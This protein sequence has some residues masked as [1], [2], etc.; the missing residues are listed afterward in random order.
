MHS[1]SVVKAPDFDRHSSPDRPLVA[2]FVGVHD[3]P[4]ASAPEPQ[5]VCDFFRNHQGVHD[6]VDG[7]PSDLAFEA[8]SSVHHF[9]VVRTLAPLVSRSC[10]AHAGVRG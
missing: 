10:P 1:L 3:R 9:P 4:R 5:L 7:R 8:V 6:S 2:A